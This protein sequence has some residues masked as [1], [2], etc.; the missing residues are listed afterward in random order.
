MTAVNIYANKKACYKPLYY[1]YFLSCFSCLFEYFN[2][3]PTTWHSPGN[4]LAQK[5]SDLTPISLLGCSGPISTLGG[6]NIHHV[7]SFVRALCLSFP[8]SLSFLTFLFVIHCLL[9]Q[10]FVIYSI[11]HYLLPCRFIRLGCK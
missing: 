1:L 6:S 10:N 4:L 5:W 2:S 7:Q 8:F 9:R 3:D 11:F